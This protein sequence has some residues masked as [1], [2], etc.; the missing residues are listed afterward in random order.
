MEF[1]TRQST[2]SGA[3]EIPASKSHT[4]RALAIAS[5]AE[6]E[7]RLARPL[8]S[9]DTDACVNVCRG[10]GARVEAAGD[11][12][13]VRGVAGAPAA[14]DDVLDVQNSGTTLY[15]ALG[16]AALLDAAAVFTG[17][18]QIRRR[19]AGPLLAAL[20]DLGAR[21]WSTRGN[22]AAPIVVQG[23]LRG[24]RTRIECPTSQY[25]T[26][27]LICSPLAREPVEIEVPLLH[28][29]PYVHMTLG[30]L[31]EQGVRYERKDLDWFRIEPRQRYRAFEKRI[32]AD[33]SSAAFFMVAAAVTGSELTLLGL[34]M[35]DAQ[36]DKAVARMLEEMGAEVAVSPE[37]LRIA[38]R[39]LKAG[40]FDLN[41]TPDALPAMAVAAAFADGETRLVN[42]PQ[43]R[44]KETDRI[45]VMCE[46][47]TRLGAD[48]EE[49]EDG[50]IVRGG[51]L[52]GG[53][54]RGHGD[55]RVVMA[56]AVAGL[57][58]PEPVVVDTAEAA[59]ITFP[60][61]AELLQSAGG[62][63]ETRRA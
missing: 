12:L 37:G 61:F 40:E 23:P 53:R 22:G 50:L 19:P 36:G 39:G 28:E 62:D 20:N 1:I 15:I 14:P 57:A 26:S 52:R 24:G 59:A 42:V 56:L 44:L 30:W 32:P 60:N 31:D 8:R 29:R 49:L 51:G 18:E 58:S 17:D 13:L 3:V 6:G 7:S 16:M 2:L 27:L 34:D 21:A 9:R 47:L 41:A 54:A 43:A 4:I 10:L 45:A 33:F 5:L 25:L 11:D 38:G 63:I 55:H 48:C 46:E 35:N